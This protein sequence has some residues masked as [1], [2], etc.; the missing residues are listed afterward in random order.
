MHG[1]ALLPLTPDLS[2]AQP[3]DR[4]DAGEGH[5][6]RAGEVRRRGPGGPPQATLLIRATTS[7]EKVEKVVS[8]PQKPVMTNSRHSGGTAV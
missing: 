5:E 2:A 7:A 8:P 1:R 3:R 4:A 6:Q